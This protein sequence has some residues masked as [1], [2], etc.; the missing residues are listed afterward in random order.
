MSTRVSGSLLLLIALVLAFNVVA[1]D[2]AQPTTAMQ[3]TQTDLSGTYTGTFNC[4]AAG[5]MGDTTLTITGNQFTTADGKSGRIVASTTGGYTAVALQIGESTP[6][7]TTGMTPTATAAAAPPPQII[8]LRARKS[9]QRLTL[10]S[11]P[12]SMQ[13]CTFTP[14][15]TTARGRRTPRTPAATGTEVANPAT[16]PVPTTSPETPMPEQTPSPAPSPSPTESPSPEPS[17]EPN[18]SPSPQPT[19]MPTPVPNPSPS[20]TVSPTPSPTPS[21]A[22][23][24]RR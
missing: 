16:A 6:A 24:R 2:P 3:S 17:P 20:P 7:A 14:T 10:M 23:L 18:P 4:E 9:G 11:V 21:P 5:L 22:G 12:G 13:K 8:S 1:Q 15:R 19:Q